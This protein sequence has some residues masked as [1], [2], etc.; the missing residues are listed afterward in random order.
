M[1]FVLYK[2]LTFPYYFGYRASGGKRGDIIVT[3][4]GSQSS[5]GQHAVSELVSL[6]LNEMQCVIII[7]A[8]SAVCL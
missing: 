4:L 3:H 5:C 8:V 1:I 6:V 7:S 2:L